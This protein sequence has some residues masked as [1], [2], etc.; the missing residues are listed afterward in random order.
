MPH[1]DAPRRLRRAEAILA[2]R[3][4]RL[5]LVSERCVDPH[6]L[7]AM[8]RT[9]ELLGVQNFY[10]IEADDY[11]SE[12]HKSTVSSGAN[13]WIDIH[14]Y[15]CASDCIDHLREKGYEIW[16]TDLDDGAIAAT[17]DSMP[18]IP[19]KLA[20]VMGREA[21]GISAEMRAAA[22]K[23]VYLPMHGFTESF[24]LGVATGMMLQRILD[25]DPTIIG[26]MPDSQRN[27]LRRKWYAKLGGLGW[28]E[29]YRE[30]LENPP[31]PL[32]DVRPSEE[33][34]S[35]RMKKSLARRLN[36]KPKRDAT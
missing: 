6:N 7:A 5:V 17:P 28:E 13:S 29:I 35:P 26:A 24:N 1:S 23:L 8:L 16:A 30:W 14:N 20:I 12:Q 19:A 31:E 36:I 21:D 11:I 2:K 9:A 4:T 25:A 33:S 3:T 10:V 34:R 15:S 18:E 27:A 22:D 32:D